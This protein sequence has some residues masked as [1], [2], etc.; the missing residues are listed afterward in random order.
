VHTTRKLLGLCVVGVAFTYLVRGGDAPTVKGNDKPPVVM[1]AFK[2]DGNYVPKLSFGLGLEMWKDNDTQKVTA[3]YVSSVRSDSP[4]EKKGITARTRVF[5]VDGVPVENLP[6]SFVQGTPLNEK[7]VHRLGGA[8][9]VL[10][11][12]I[13]GDPRSRVV[14]LEEA[15]S[16]SLP[17][18]LERYH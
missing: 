13:P 8:R 10:E 5:R 7:F 6:A 16:N 2:V 14:T 12:G 18:T 17:G 3:L 9:V 1:E 15:R 11:I 4:A